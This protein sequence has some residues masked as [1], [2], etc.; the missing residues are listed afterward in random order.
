[1]RVIVGGEVGLGEV[2]LPPCGLLGDLGRCEPTVGRSEESPRPWL[3]VDEGDG[4]CRRRSAEGLGGWGVLCTPAGQSCQP[5]RRRPGVTVVAHGHH[6]P[7]PCSLPHAS[8]ARAAGRGPGPRPDL[9]RVPGV[10][11]RSGSQE[12]VWAFHVVS[13]WH[14]RSLSPKQPW[15]WLPASEII[16][17]SY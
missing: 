11:P 4:R 9:S 10:G 3:W 14:S 17:G 2:W 16:G 13:A 8:Q 15:V 7:L 6:G 1:M 12:P 5:R